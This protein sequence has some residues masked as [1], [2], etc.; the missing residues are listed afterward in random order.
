M[1]LDF[2]SLAKALKSLRRAVDRAQEVPGDEELRD[3][4]IQRFE[5]SYELCWKMIKRQL[6]TEV[7]VPADVDT[8]SFKSLIREAAERG[9][10]QSV[11]P[12]LIYREQRNI[13]AHTYDGEKAQEVYQTAVEFLPAAC[14]LLAELERRSR[15]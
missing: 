9:L 4:V 14:A 11:E 13:T 2:S 15:D 1:K 10:V 8:L 6:E 3:A 7:A 5:Y 12:W